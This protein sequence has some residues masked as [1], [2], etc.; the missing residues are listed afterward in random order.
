[1]S[2]ETGTTVPHTPNTQRPLPPEINFHIPTGTFSG[3]AEPGQV[4]KLT[5]TVDEHTR[6]ATAGKDGRWEIVMGRE[7]RWYTIFKIWACD[8]ATGATSHTTSYT[9]GGNPVMLKDVYASRSLVSGR[10][11]PGTEITVFGPAGQTLGRAFVFGC[12]SGWSVKFREPLD[13]GEKICVIASRADGSTSMPLYVKAETFSV[14]DRNVGRIAGAGASAG[15]RI[16]IID[17]A[18]DQKITEATVTEAGNWS[19]EF[20]DLLEPGTRISIERLHQDGSS[21]KGPIVAVTTH[22]CPAPVLDLI[23]ASEVAGTARPGLLVHYEQRRDD[24]L[25]VSKKVHVPSSGTWAVPETDLKEGDSIVV[26]TADG[27]GKTT[28][29]LYTS[30]IVGRARPGIPLVTSMSADCASGYANPG[31]Y[32]VAST[33]ADG[34]IGWSKVEDDASWE[35]QWTPLPDWSD[36]T[37][38]V[39]FTVHTALAGTGHDKPSSH[40]CIRY[41]SESQTIPPKPVITSWTPATATF[42][43]TEGMIKTKIKIFDTNTGS[44]VS[45]DPKEITSTDWTEYADNP[46]SPG[47][48]VYAQAIGTTDSG[49]PGATSPNSAYFYC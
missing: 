13:A 29:Q 22:I 43:G 48:Q 24:Q 19:A 9:F 32:I 21:S 23:S 8:P 17:V 37:L 42:A 6:L 7:P 12:G 1:M 14:D 38:L 11:R 16:E 41:A 34:V 44:T 28:S 47:D 18:S 33:T 15:D 10:A 25:V 20:S 36:E 2:M 35:V 49:D 39:H 40:A 5:N 3:T 27:S 30:A 4:I 31:D 26:T 45:R 46:P